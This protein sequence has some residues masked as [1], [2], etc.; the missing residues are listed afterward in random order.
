MANLSLFFPE[1]ATRRLL[2]FKTIVISAILLGAMV[3]QIAG[4]SLAKMYSV[5]QPS[6]ATNPKAKI[7][8]S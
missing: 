4:T 1:I 8:G 5:Y 7:L 2:C 6:A 3:K